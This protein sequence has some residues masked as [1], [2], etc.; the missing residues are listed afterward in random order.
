MR[1]IKFRGKDAVGNK[2]W[3]YGD[4]VHNQKVTTT[5]LEPRVMV[6]G[7]EV[8][9]NTI[10]QFTGVTD[11][12]GREIYEGDIIKVGAACS[13]YEVTWCTVRS[14]FFTHCPGS[15]FFYLLDYWSTETVIAGNIHDNPE[16]LK[17]E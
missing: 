17:N 6:A 3:V 14:G 8:V 15:K 12:N 11:K 2:G 13:L 10:G 5:G 4:L 7:Y 16:L 1:E 9:E